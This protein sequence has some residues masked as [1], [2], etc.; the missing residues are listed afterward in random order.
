[1]PAKRTAKTASAVPTAKASG[2]ATEAPAVAPAAASPAKPAKKASAAK[3]TAAKA[4]GAKATEAKATEAKAAET[5]APVKKAPAKKA[6]SKQAAPA[7]TETAPENERAL[8]MG[9]SAE[10]ESAEVEHVPANRA[11]RRARG[12][13]GAA[14]QPTSRGKVVGGKG[15]VS[16]QRMWANRRSG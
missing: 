8:D 12:K 1:M 13:S 14:S 15:P 3:T 9:Q 4:S 10:E 2:E 6:P 5:E 16:T 7:A 11:E